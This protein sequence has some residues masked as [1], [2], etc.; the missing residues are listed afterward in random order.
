MSRKFFEQVVL[1][2]L[3]AV[4]STF[5]LTM[6]SFLDFGTKSDL[7]Y[8]EFF[9]KN[10]M[11][12]RVITSGHSGPFEVDFFN[13]GENYSISRNVNMTTDYEKDSI[14]AVYAKGEYEI[15]TVYE[16]RYITQEEFDSEAAVCVVGKLVAERSLK[17]GEDG[18]KYFTHY[19]VDYE[20]VGYIGVT[21][22]TD[23]DN[24]VILNMKC[25]NKDMHY[26]ASYYIDSVDAESVDAVKNN[27][28]AQFDE[29]L[30]AEYCKVSVNFREHTSVLDMG[31]ATTLFYIAFGVL[32]INVI[33]S[34]YQYINQ[35]AYSDAVKKLCG[36]S[37][38]GVIA[39]LMLNFFVMTTIGFIFGAAIKDPVFSKII[40]M[41]DEAVEIP[42]GYN[43]AIVAYIAVLAFSLIV[44]FVTA[45]KIYYRDTSGYLKAKD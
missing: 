2:F 18:K 6:I 19:G 20:V 43:G 40:K 42:E 5:V 30:A 23:L 11:S 1:T 14:R 31:E 7:N 22:S 3:F 45:R 35:R 15:P 8:N 25:F 16:G 13:L 32:I 21:K 17:E 27:F 26:L 28:V 36:F 9:S 10:A 41:I 37:M 33:L 24:M 34:V 4:V 44:A 12:V 39:E 29:E 38:V